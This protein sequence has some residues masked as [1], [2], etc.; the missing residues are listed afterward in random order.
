MK[1]QFSY[2]GFEPTS[3]IYLN[4]LDL[5]HEARKWARSRYLSIGHAFNSKKMQ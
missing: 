1:T 3:G 5:S 4:F 2:T